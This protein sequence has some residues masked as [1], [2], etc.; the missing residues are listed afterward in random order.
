M[1]ASIDIKK[2]SD[3]EF[4]RS[5]GVPPTRNATIQTPGQLL[6]NCHLIVASILRPGESETFLDAPEYNRTSDLTVGHVP[7]RFVGDFLTNNFLVPRLCPAARNIG[8]ELGDDRATDKGALGLI[9]V[10][11]PETTVPDLQRGRE[12]DHEVGAFS[13][14]FRG[15]R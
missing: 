11:G 1:T 7:H 9:E 12:T 5:R 2:R 6:A 3:P 8:P 4:I 15:L 14:L 10:T 13:S